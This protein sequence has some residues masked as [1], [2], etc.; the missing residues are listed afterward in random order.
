MLDAR[1]SLE[2]RRPLKDTA[3]ERQGTTS[4][5]TRNVYRLGRAITWTRAQYWYRRLSGRA[6][7]KDALSPVGKL[8]TARRE[9]Q[10]A[11]E[12]RRSFVGA[13]AR[14][15]QI[16]PAAALSYLLRA[17][18]CSRVI[19]FRGSLTPDNYSAVVVNFP[20]NKRPTTS[21][22]TLSRSA[23]PAGSRERRY[24]FYDFHGPHKDDPFSLGRRWR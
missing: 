21:A 9:Q 12:F 2:K 10:P 8:G 22:L 3:E 7:G 14:R 17:P 18:L 23:I 1:V 11:T 15:R 16:R 6:R 19:T 13:K 24:Q 5:H 20:G 4:A